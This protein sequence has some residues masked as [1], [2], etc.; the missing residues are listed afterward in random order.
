[1]AFMLGLAEARQGHRGDLDSFGSEEGEAAPGSRAVTP[2]D[3]AWF[4]DVHPEMFR[5]PP[6]EA[7]RGQVDKV[8]LRAGGSS[9]HGHPRVNICEVCAEEG[10]CGECK[11]VCCLGSAALPAG[12]IMPQW[13][14]LDLAG[15]TS[16]EICPCCSKGRHQRRILLGR[17]GGTWCVQCGQEG[18]YGDQ[19]PTASA[20]LGV[21]ASTLQD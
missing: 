7:T 14:P 13:R 3:E 16:A 8:S 18:H 9:A 6:N 15:S 11:G 5:E 10:E 12:F 21:R 4:R 17:T 1:M 20:C 2:D 19:C